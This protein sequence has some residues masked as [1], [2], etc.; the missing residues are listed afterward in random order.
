M[1]KSTGFGNPDNLRVHGSV[2][3]MA[4]WRR[5]DYQRILRKIGRFADKMTV[6]KAINLAAKRAADAGVTETRR[7]IT[8]A[9]T[10]RPEKI[11]RAIRAYKYGS[12]LSMSIGMKISDT[13]HRLGRFSFSP[14]K[15]PKKPKQVISEVKRGQKDKFTKGAFVGKM[16]NGSIGI[17]EREKE[18]RLPI[19]SLFG[20]STTGMFTA[21][22]NIHDD[23]WEKIFDTFDKR[24]VH[25]LRRL[26]D[27]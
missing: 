15:P 22:K 1:S 16:P 4:E 23:V 2:E 8:R 21:N 26:L 6:R 17:F 12:A 5:E 14:K 3:V 18:S 19:T 10:L 25:E 9:Y 7:Q 24:V 13:A 20:P 27:G 11:K